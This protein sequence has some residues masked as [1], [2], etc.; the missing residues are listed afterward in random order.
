MFSLSYSEGYGGINM[1]NRDR[2][3]NVQYG[4]TSFTKNDKM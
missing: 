2:I 3:Q 1:V 4:D